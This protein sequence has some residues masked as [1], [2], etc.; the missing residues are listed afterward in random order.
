MFINEFLDPKK[1]YKK[2]HHMVLWLI[3]NLY[4][5]SV[6]SILSRFTYFEIVE[7]H[8]EVGRF[9][10][11]GCPLLTPWNLVVYKRYTNSYLMQFMELQGIS[12]K[13]TGAFK[14][15]CRI[16]FWSIY[17][18]K[19]C[20]KSGLISLSIYRIHNKK[21]F[22]LCFN[23]INELKICKYILKNIFESFF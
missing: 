8:L 6:M 17:L 22:I 9:I 4:W 13:C 3:T 21:I 19:S 23:L 10:W 2:T 20:R 12:E 11:N 18:S 5:L 1:T 14:F 15:G 7:L 16:I